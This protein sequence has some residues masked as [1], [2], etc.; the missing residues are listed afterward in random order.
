MQCH[1][2]KVVVALADWKEKFLA[3]HPASGSAKLVVLLAPPTSQKTI[4]PLDET[5]GYELKTLVSAPW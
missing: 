3:R 2:F 5:G 1:G 4:Q